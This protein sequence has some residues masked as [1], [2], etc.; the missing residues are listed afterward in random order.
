[1]MLPVSPTF[2]LTHDDHLPHNTLASVAR[3]CSDR[4]QLGMSNFLRRNPHAVGDL[5]LAYAYNLEGQLSSVTYPTDGYGTTPQFT[6]QFDPM[7]RPSG[8]TD[9]TNFSVVNNVTYGPAN[10]LT[11]IYFYGQDETR[12]YNSMLQL[13]NITNTLN[14][15]A[16]LN[17][18][19][20]FPAAGANAGKIMSQTDN[21]SG[22]TINYLYDSL[23]RLNVSRREQQRVVTNLQLRRLRQPNGPDG[24]WNRVIDHDQH[25][26]RSHY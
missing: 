7:M 20:T 12:Q 23:N 9:Q 5:N 10:E 26:G 17:V 16:T 6:Y 24:V 11:H 8:M 21:V 19:Y 25:T 18:T 14:S 1:M 4:L 13:T 3:R 15:S 22:E 2:F